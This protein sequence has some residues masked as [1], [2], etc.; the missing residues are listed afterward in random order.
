[1]TGPQAVR[2]LLSL[3]GDTR[4]AH[5][6]L[7]RMEALMER[8]GHPQRAYRVVH[9]AGTNGKGSTAAMIEAGLRSAGH[10]TGLYT[11]PH[12]VRFNERLRI[13]G[14]EGGD[15]QFAAA[16]EEVRAA[17]EWL[18]A[19]KGPAAHPTFFESVTAAAFCGFRR[20]AVDWGVIEVGLGGRL[21]ATNVVQPEVAVVT[22]IALDHEAFLG[23]SGA[24]IAAEKAGILKP[25]CE[26]VFATQT[27]QAATVLAARAAA[28]GVPVTRIGVDWIAEDTSAERGY[29]RFNARRTGG[30][31]L[32]AR[33]A[34]AG[35]HQ[36][37]NALAAIAALDRLGIP[38]TAIAQGLETVRWPG[39]LQSVAGHPE[40]LLDAAHNPAGARVLASFL[41]RH[42]AGRRVHLIYGTSRDKAV[43][44][45]AGLLF[46]CAN[47]VILTRANVA[48]SASP[49]TL[50]RMVDHHHD[51][52]HVE[53]VLS[54][55]MERARREAA[56]EDL[57]VICG[58]VFL[59]GEALGL[60][61]S[62][63]ALP[64]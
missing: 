56:P 8:L 33:L 4:G 46:P 23:K 17:N 54:G 25:G 27:A 35:E 59:V 31:R 62:V 2:Y 7:Q 5:F 13:N 52:I 50:L 19:R 32:E 22:P 20:A 34:L 39:R 26:A 3:L 61:Q 51:T 64:V 45:V 49:E 21:D 40:I 44:E 42:H 30:M 63:E 12:L 38:P 28:L 58:S 16:V 18:L 47:R 37:E 60:L 15:G 9:V 29:Y 53:A 11:S 43:D 55:A 10:T 14:A 36:V 1:M 6:G 41:A 48:R 57:I 24:S